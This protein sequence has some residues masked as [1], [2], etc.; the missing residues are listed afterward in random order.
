LSTSRETTLTALLAS[1]RRAKADEDVAIAI[2]RAVDEKI[3]ALFT[4][5]ASGEGAVTERVDGHSLTVTFGINRKVDSDKLKAGFADLA[6]NV[7]NAFRWKGEVDVK[8]YRA[9]QGKDAL[10]AGKFVTATPAAV[11]VGVKA[12]VTEAA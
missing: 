3:A 1:R 5:P 9:L 4:K 7:Q 2:R 10:A 11:S 12:L 8:A 6:V